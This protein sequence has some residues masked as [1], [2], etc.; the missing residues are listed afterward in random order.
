MIF[1]H[2]G[3]LVGGSV[4]E[5]DMTDLAAR[6]DAVVV[7][8]AY[9]LQIFGWLALPGLSAREKASGGRAS[10]GNYGLL[11]Q[12]LGM[13]WV[14]QNID[15]FSGDPNRVMIW[16]QSSGGTSCLAHLT[17]PA[18]RGL[19][20]SVVSLSGSPNI[21]M[22]LD[23]A[24]KQNEPIQKSLGC[25]GKDVSCL[26]DASAQKL[27]AAPPNM[28]NQDLFGIPMK[29]G[30]MTPAQLPGLLIVD[31]VTV[32]KP[33]A[34]AFKEP[35]DDVPVVLSSMAQEGDFMPNALQ[36]AEYKS[37]PANSYQE[38]IKCQQ[39]WPK[40]GFRP[41]L[42]KVY[43]HET[44]PE[45][46]NPDLYHCILEHYAEDIKVSPLKAY[47]SINA[48]TGITCGT[49]ALANVAA[50]HRTKPV[51]MVVSSA[52]PSSTFSEGIYNIMGMAMTFAYHAY[53]L[54]ATGP[55]L[56]L[57]TAADAKYG[58]KVSDMLGAMAHR[59]ELTEQGFVAVG[60][61]KGVVTNNIG[62][63][64]V[65]EHVQGWRAGVCS[66]CWEA[67]GIGHDYYWAD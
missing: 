24:Y 20:H 31:G 44:F 23:S 3:S 9:R 10:S 17:S 63:E 7:A 29:P 59:G 13:R 25:H 5:F 54:I 55:M 60:V 43:S 64:G 66:K 18:A 56:P 48:D 67:N 33:V 8:I 49:M 42:K 21:T 14:Q 12:Q 51:Y 32:P 22:S 52:T 1:F 45:Q 61:S 30:G 28:W 2:G 65:I 6:E 19:F 46:S 62:D 27:L 26:L 53:D 35:L 11:D 58:H 4:N 15:G 34:D 36:I 16:G 50:Q 38:T 37:C 39:K 57:G 40:E 41:W 47:S